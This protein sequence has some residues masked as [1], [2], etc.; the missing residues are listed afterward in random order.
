MKEVY[1]DLRTALQGAANLASELIIAENSNDIERAEIAL[2]YQMN[3]ISM[4]MSKIRDARY[5]RN[6]QH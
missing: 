4:A 2:E 6:K 1:I 3:S 5:Q